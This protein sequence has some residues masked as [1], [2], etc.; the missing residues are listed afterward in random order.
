MCKLNDNNAQES[1]NLRLPIEKDGK[2]MPVVTTGTFLGALAMVPIWATVVLP[3][4]TIFQIGKAII[5]PLS[6][7]PE[8]P[9]YDSGYV[10]DAKDITPRPQRKYDVVLLGATGFT[11]RLGARH[12]AKTYGVNQTVRWAIAGRSQAKLDKVKTELAEELGIPEILNVDTIL[13]DT[14][15]ASTLP[16]LVRDTR[17][18]VTTAG[19]FSLYGSSAVEFCAKFGTHYTDITGEITWVQKMAA[20]WE[21]TAQ[22]TGAKIVSLCGH[23]SIPW[24]LVTS[25]VAQIL[26]EEKG[27][28][29]ASI[30]IRNECYASASGGTLLTMSL[31]LAGKLVQPP[32][33]DPFLAKS[34]NPGLKVVN[35]LPTSISK[36]IL[37]WNGQTKYK[38]P[39]VMAVVNMQVVEWSQALRGS[40]IPLAYSEYSINPDFKTAFVGYFGLIGIVSAL[41]NPITASLLQRFVLEKPGGGPS[42]DAMEKDF[43]LVLHADGVGSKG[44]PAEAVMYFSQDPGY[45]HTARMVVEAGLGLALTEDQLPIQEGGFLTPSVALG[46]VLLK[47]LQ[48]TGTYFSSRLKANAN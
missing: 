3:L 11:G 33:T 18:V 38:S 4:T 27:E 34:K 35:N 8:E 20:T 7:K 45:L 40:S 13:V 15:N 1:T 43:F 31:G 5:K 14:S 46:D 16:A 29:L 21:T 25:K 19:P 32:A 30:D 17:A 36:T 37:P 10:V 24:D 42:M 12:L 2:S 48:D 41:L 28:D 39:F 6:P 22:Q 23:D 44:T 47:R 26:K 9:K